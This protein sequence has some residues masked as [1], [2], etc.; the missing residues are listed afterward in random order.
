MTEFEGRR[1]V[2]IDPARREVARRGR[3]RAGPDDIDAGDG[4]LWA[5]GLLIGPNTRLWRIDPRSSG[6]S[7]RSTTP[8]SSGRS[9]PAPTEPGWRTT[10]GRSTA[11]RRVGALIAGSRSRSAA[12]S[13]P[14]GAGCGTVPGRYGRPHR[15]ALRA[16][17]ASVAP[18]APAAVL[19]AGEAIVAD[20]RGRGCSAPARGASSASRATAWCACCGSTTRG[21]ELRARRRRPVGGHERR[22]AGPR[23]ARVDPRTGHGDRDG[24]ARHALP[25]RARPCPGGLWVVSGDGTVLLVDA[26]RPRGPARTPSARRARRSV[27]SRRAPRSAT[28]CSFGTQCVI[29]EAL[30]VARAVVAEVVEALL[31]G[32]APALRRDRL[33]VRT[34]SAVMPRPSPTRWPSS[35]SH[36]S[37]CQTM[38]SWIGR[39]HSPSSVDEVADE[40][41]L[42]PLLGE[43]V[44]LA[45]LAVVVRARDPRARQAPADLRALLVRARASAPRP[46]RR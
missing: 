1:I 29:D 24:R 33:E 6:S 14:P 15:R 18:L 25:A 42:L 41:V 7:T 20:E 5:R 39:S 8:T 45:G 34:S 27:R 46:A 32:L 13:P 11:S 40:V 16:H 12:T 21:A 36:R 4:S 2:R 9:R 30:D 10:T 23:L 19:E 35:S 43:L 22:P 17:R 37:R 44:A 26:G 28:T 3:A 38:R 31:L